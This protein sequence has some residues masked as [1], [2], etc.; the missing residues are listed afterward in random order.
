[1]G[2]L[3]ASAEDLARG[4]LFDPGLWY[5][6]KIASHDKK[7]AADGKSINHFFHLTCIPIG[8][9]DADQFVGSSPGVVFNEKYLDVRY[10]EFCTALGAEKDADGNIAIDPDAVDGEVLEVFV[11]HRIDKNDKNKVYNDCKSFRKVGAGEDE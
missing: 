7:P 8:N 2:M 10:G 1:M 5:R 11:T 4:V 3:K 9:P 6:V